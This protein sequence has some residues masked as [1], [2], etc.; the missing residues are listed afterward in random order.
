M[1]PQ[2][3]GLILHAGLLAVAAGLA[4]RVWTRSDE[5]TLAARTEVTVWSGSPSAVTSVSFEGERRKVRLEARE[6]KVGRYY[7]VDVDRTVE[8]PR[9]APP[10]D[11]GVEAG[12]P[13]PALET[14]HELQRFIS[15]EGGD[16]LTRSLAPFRALRALGKVPEGQAA[17]FGFDKP[18]GT[19]RVDVGGA[20]HT[21][22]LGGTTPGGGDRYARVAETGE[23]YAIPGDVSRD[24][25]YAESRLFER[26]LHAWKPDDAKNV[27]I[28]RGQSVRELVRVAGKRDAWA[29]AASPSRQDET[30]GNW[31]TKLER[32]RASAYDEKPSPAPGPEHLVFRAAFSAGSRPLGY[33]EL[34]KLPGEPGK[35]E[36]TGEA[37]ES[38]TKPPARYLVKTEG[39]RFYVEV[40]RSSAEQLE[41][42]AASVLK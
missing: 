18:A 8:T 15:V 7:V 33:L 30:A 4:A 25:E 14:R 13:A 22:V 23:V 27:R 40:L 6:D 11:G 1:S 26:E 24:L 10:A 41:Q 12:A 42:D 32:L 31:V 2:L 5:A 29:D 37:V 35:G 16:K 21:L 17:E 39:S 9:T 34:Y 28:T 36:P 20:R 19:I 3:R 38:P